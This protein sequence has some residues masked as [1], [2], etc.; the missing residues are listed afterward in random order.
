MKKIKK[1]ISMI[2]IMSFVFAL[3]VIPTQAATIKTIAV[4][5]YVSYSGTKDSKIFYK[6]TVPADGVVT[7]YFAQGESLSVYKKAS[8]NSTQY[9]E[10]YGEEKATVALAKGTYYLYAEN[11]Y[12]YDYNKDVEKYFHKFK[13]TFKQV[14]YG[15][16]YCM[17]R[18]S[19]LKANNTINVIQTK[20]KNYSRWY[21]IALP[22]NQKLTVYT[23]GEVSDGYDGVCIY[24]KQYKSIGM[25]RVT[26]GAYRSK[27]TLAK[28]TYYI[29][30]FSVA[31]Y[32]FSY[33]TAVLTRLK[34]K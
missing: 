12:T 33:S 30:V 1:I 9:E 4:N 21:K 5:T 15:S 23:N 25:K 6:L 26:S 10:V 19:S 20:K 2:L 7:L 31:P 3:T 17:S 29:K 32:E 34:W 8:T 22:K 16:N 14:N 11:E 13:Y 28:G 24:N 27:T 18:A